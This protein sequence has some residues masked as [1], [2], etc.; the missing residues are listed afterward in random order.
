MA[1]WLPMASGFT[2][3][4]TRFVDPALGFCLGWNYWFKVCPTE[5]MVAFACFT[6]QSPAYARWKTANKRCSTLS[7]PRTILLLPRSSSN[8][9]SR[10]KS[11]TLEFSLPFSWSSLWPSTTLV[12]DSLESLNSIFPVSKSSSLLLWSSW[13]WFLHVEVVQRE[14]P[15]ALHIGGIPELLMLTFWVS[16]HVPCGALDLNAN[17]Q[18]RVL[19]VDFW[20]SGPPSPPLYS[21]TWEPNWWV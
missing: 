8:T 6:P 11:S 15:R 19:L 20:Q 2:G 3:Y 16:Y 1:C 18:Q 21:L 12:W 10:E 4:A 9:G 5:Y 7:L 14:M 13:V 17:K